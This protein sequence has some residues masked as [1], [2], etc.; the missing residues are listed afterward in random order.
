[1]GFMQINLNKI[2]QNN[3]TNSSMFLI[4][5]QKKISPSWTPSTK[6]GLRRFR[7]EYRIPQTCIEKIDLPTMTDRYLKKWPIDKLLS[8]YSSS[9]EKKELEDSLPILLDIASKEG[10]NVFGYH[11][12]LI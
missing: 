3:F 10:E 4:D 9:E 7:D 5:K 11:G 6:A 1:M 12:A 8:N 2:Q